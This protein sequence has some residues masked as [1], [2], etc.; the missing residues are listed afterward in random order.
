MNSC[1]L[2]YFSMMLTGGVVAV[3]VGGTGVGVSVG[4]MGVA[5]GGAILAVGGTEVGM[6]V[7]IIGL[8]EVAQ[9]ASTTRQVQ[10]NANKDNFFSI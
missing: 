5:D 10:I 7:T 2:G 6:L 8:P 9:P 1:P 4:G 3:G